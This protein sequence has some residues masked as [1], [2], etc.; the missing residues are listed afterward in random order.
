LHKKLPHF[1]QNS[2][3][4]EYSEEV[5]SQILASV[6]AL[7]MLESNKSVASNEVAVLIQD[8][9]FDSRGGAKLK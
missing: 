8:H 2:K 1:G 9:G 6:T 5:L 7:N 3:F 4:F